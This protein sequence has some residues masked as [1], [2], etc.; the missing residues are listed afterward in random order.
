MEINK[1]LGSPAH[2]I[3]MRKPHEDS[4]YSLA[5]PADLAG[6]LAE[7]TYDGRAYIGYTKVII[8]YAEIMSASG[9]AYSKKFLRLSIDRDAYP[10]R[11]PV[12]SIYIFTE[13]F[14]AIREH[15]GMDRES[16]AYEHALNQQ[17]MLP[18]L[19]SHI[20]FALRTN[21]GR[22]TIVLPLEKADSKK[23]TGPEFFLR[24]TITNNREDDVHIVDPDLETAWLSRGTGRAQ[25]SGSGANALRREYL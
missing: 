24:C 6:A 8:K 20:E 12:R 14:S 25:S 17:V 13:P 15:Y 21:D 3:D 18:R 9:S 4:K 10:Y 16:T 7:P 19:H 22:C 11:V 2:L 23:E 1:Y 5:H